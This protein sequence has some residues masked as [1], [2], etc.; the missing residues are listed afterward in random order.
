QNALFAQGR[1]HEIGIEGVARIAEPPAWIA[2][3]HLRDAIFH[4]EL[5][6]VGGIARVEPLDTVLRP[7][8]AHHLELG[9]TGQNLIMDAA[10]PM[11]AWT[12]LAVW[13]RRQGRTERRTETTEH[14][15]GGV[16]RNAANQQN[17]AAHVS[18]LQASMA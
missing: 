5:P 9:M 10:D 17:V 11:L 6:A 16:K 3:A 8:T 14:L 12:D 4:P 13:H 7:R 2:E 15:L 1:E 18:S